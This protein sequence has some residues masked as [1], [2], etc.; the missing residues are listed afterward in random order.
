M[1]SVYWGI[2]SF[3]SR[4]RHDDKCSDTEQNL[5]ND[6][7]FVVRYLHDYA[8]SITGELPVLDGGSSILF[9]NNEI[10]DGTILPRKQIHIVSFHQVHLISQHT[11]VNVRAYLM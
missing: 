10:Q 9:M 6:V 11:R 2:I 1:F 7:R 5:F 3:R 8:Q 4:R